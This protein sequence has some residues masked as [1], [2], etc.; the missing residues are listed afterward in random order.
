MFG[1]N[2]TIAKAD[3]ATKPVDALAEMRN[4][5]AAAT[6]AAEKGGVFARLIADYFEGSLAYW[7]QRASFQSDQANVTRMHDQHG[8]LINHHANVARAETIREEKKRLASEQAWQESVNRRAEAQAERDSY[9][10]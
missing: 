5:I 7:R 10:R 9:I 8:N 3:T 1:K 6:S 4:A 2:K